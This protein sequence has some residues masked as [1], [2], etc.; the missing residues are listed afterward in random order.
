M[1]ES[2]E[3]AL[4]L[5]G[6]RIAAGI[7]KCL[8]RAGFRVA[9]DLNAPLGELRLAILV[10]EEDQDV[11]KS[12]ISGIEEKV[13]ADTLIAVNTE[14]IGLDIL[15]EN[16]LYP[17]R[18]IG[19]N[20]TEPADQTFFL[21]I[22]ANDTTNASAADYLEEIA[23]TCWNKDP[24]VIRA[25]TGIRMRLRG[26]LI[27]EA[28]FLVQNGY[29]NVEDI[30]RACRNDAGYYLPFA[31]NLRYMDLMGTY[32]YGMVMKDLNRELAKDTEL[33]AFFTDI[34]KK[35]GRRMEEGGGF[36][37]YAE[38]ESEK[39]E[40]LLAKFS[41]EIHELME[42]YNHSEEAVVPFRNGSN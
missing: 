33:P 4:L 37:Q 5:G 19:L 2:N 20:W 30:D 1:K 16:A 11:K 38:G 41:M 29:A 36:Y 25:N 21:E 15:Q 18:I 17:G 40:R 10:T 39:W 32:A 13:S 14:S 9:T 42:K 3:A 27:R 12:W 22:I 24:Y 31:G 6:H 23:K 35:G 7:E 34:V 8:N 28:F 26:A